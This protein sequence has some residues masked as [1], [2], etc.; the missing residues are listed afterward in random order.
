MMRSWISAILLLWSVCLAADDSVSIT[1]KRLATTDVFAIGR[2]GYA[3]LI[4]AGEMDFNYIISQPHD[5][6]ETAFLEL[7]ATGNAQAK[8]YALF[9]IRK[10]N[11]GKFKELLATLTKSPETVQTEVGCIV[12]HHLLRD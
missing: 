5:A 4:S 8:A 1:L 2:V 6:A 12:S 3:G 7:Y 11:E 9:G 10:L